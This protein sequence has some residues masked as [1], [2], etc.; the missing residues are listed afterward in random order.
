MDVGISG[1][2][3]NGK[4]KHLPRPGKCKLTRIISGDEE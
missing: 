1:R 4:E 3:E 2:R